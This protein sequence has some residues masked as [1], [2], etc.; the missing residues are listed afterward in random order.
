MNP[1]AAV[2]N[3]LRYSVL[4]STVAASFP[5]PI[6]TN[7]FLCDTATQLQGDVSLPPCFAFEDS[8]IFLTTLYVLGLDPLSHFKLKLM[9]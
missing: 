6:F 1:I 7:T 9:Q 5:V 2:F 3:F 8:R 4:F